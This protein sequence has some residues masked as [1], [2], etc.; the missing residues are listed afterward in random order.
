MIVFDV[1]N[2]IAGKKTDKK[3]N[4]ENISFFCKHSDLLTQKEG[5]KI[6]SIPCYLIWSY[7]SKTSVALFEHF[8]SLSLL[9]EL[10][11]KCFSMEKHF[12]LLYLKNFWNEHIRNLIDCLNLGDL[13]IN[14]GS[15]LSNFYSLHKQIY[16]KTS[17]ICASSSALLSE[18]LQWNNNSQSLMLPTDIGENI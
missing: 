18:K 10:L 3:E 4:S 15:Y 17:I 6:K 13:P 7:D 11:F 12:D 1:L 14:L 8:S 5:K 2:R 9:L 16:H